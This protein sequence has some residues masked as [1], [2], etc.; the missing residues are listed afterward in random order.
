[1]QIPRPHPIIKIAQDDCFITLGK[2]FADNAVQYQS[3]RWPGRL[4]LNVERED[5]TPQEDGTDYATHFQA[6]IP[7]YVVIDEDCP[8]AWSIYEQAVFQCFDRLGDLD[9]GPEVTDYYASLENRSAMVW[10][11]GTAKQAE[12]LEASATWELRELLPSEHQYEIA[13]HLEE[14]A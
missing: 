9:F 10:L 7:F 11:C 5:P 14:S 8:K 13:I 6:N 4:H 2:L 1:M 3:V 12:I